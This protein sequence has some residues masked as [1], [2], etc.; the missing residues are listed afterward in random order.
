MFLDT[1]GLK[2]IIL[3]MQDKHLNL[4]Y[5]YGA[6]DKEGNLL[7]DN[8][9][10]AF[11]QT[12]RLLSDEHRKVFLGDLFKRAKHRM[13]SD[14]IE[15]PSK[16]ESARLKGLDFKR[17]DVALQGYIP[18]NR[19]PR[20]ADFA[21][22]V[23]ISRGDKPQWQKEKKSKSCPDAWVFDRDG[24]SYCLL[25][26]CK[27]WSNNPIDPDQICRHWNEWLR[28]KGEEKEKGW[29]DIA[30]D[31]LDLTWYDVLESIKAT[32]QEPETESIPAP[33]ARDR[34][35]LEKQMLKE[36]REFLGF[37]GYWLFEG[38]SF[39]L[40]ES[41]PEWQLFSFDSSDTKRGG[42]R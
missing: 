18:S 42:R 1:T 35:E 16:E 5:A 33:E 3:S 31:L 37:Y 4:F 20:D 24:H 27:C 8:L 10:R 7:E 40:L 6:R 32:T 26:E 36:L 30:P 29:D 28:D 19:L 2:P 34:N 13:L 25:V 23:T 39:E 17:A 41:P 9:T 12:I 15:K 38:F 21:R 22:V 14:R 11:V